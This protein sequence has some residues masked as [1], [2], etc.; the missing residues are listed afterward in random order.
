MGLDLLGWRWRE[1]W[2][3]T[4]ITIYLGGVDEFTKVTQ[5]FRGNFT[6][7]IPTTSPS[8]S[9]Q[10]SSTR[11]IGSLF[12]SDLPI[13]MIVYFPLMSP[14]MRKNWFQK[15]N[16]TFLNYMK[17]N[18][19]WKVIFPIFRIFLFAFL[20]SFS[21]SPTCTHQRARKV[22]FLHLIFFRHVIR[23]MEGA[24]CLQLVLIMKKIVKKF[25]FRTFTLGTL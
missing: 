8:A 12:W 13:C 16:V 25:F 5:Y 4:K 20:K 15:G 24:K 18:W 7:L 9:N 3:D 10:S 14:N 17:E 21:F 22:V 11:I 1:Y 19:S 2:V 6:F 23:T